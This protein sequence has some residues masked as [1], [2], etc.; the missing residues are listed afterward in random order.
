VACASALWA[1]AGSWASKGPVPGSGQL[2]P[3]PCTDRR[4]FDGTTF[5]YRACG[6]PDLD[7]V[8]VTANG[9][10]GL[11][12]NG[13]NFCATTSTM[14]WLAYLAGKGFVDAPAVKDWTDQANFSEMSNEIAALGTLMGTTASGGTGGG[15]M[16]EGTEQWL[17]AH[18]TPQTTLHA[19]SGSLNFVTKSFTAGG[20]YSPETTTMLQDAVDGG[21]VMPVIGFYAN[22][23][24]PGTDV[25]HLRRVG[26]HVVSLVSGAGA[27]A[28]TAATLG[29][30]DP[31]TEWIDDDIQS[32]Y[33]T[34]VWTL[35]SASQETYFSIDEQG[36]FHEY[37]G[38][39]PS[40]NGSATTLFDGYV[41]IEPKV[42]ETVVKD[43]ILILAPI[44]VVGPPSP[45][46][47]ERFTVSARV[48]DVALAPDGT[49]VPF[50]ARGR[51]GVWQLDT[52]TGR[53]TKFAGAPRGASRLTFGGPAQTLYVAGRTRLVGIDRKGRRVGQVKLDGPL[54]DLQFDSAGNRL[55]GLSLA[56]RRLRLFD[57]RL[58]P[59]GAVR[60]P[61]AAL[62][63][64]GAPTLAITPGGKF[65][66]HRNGS[67]TLFATGAPTAQ[68][69]A[70]RL[71][72]RPH[73]IR[74]KGR[75]RGLTVDDAGH[76][77]VS[78]RGKLVE[79]TPDGRRARGSAFT[80]LPAGPELDVSRSFSN[81][82]PH[83]G[84]RSLDFLPPENQRPATPDLVFSSTAHGSFTVAN[85]GQDAAGPFKVEISALAGAP[86]VYSF[87]GLAVGGSV[88][89]AFDCSRQRVL[90]IDPENQVD[91][92]D[93][94][95]N[96]GV[97][98]AC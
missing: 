86:L 77:F 68:G 52:L 44:Q 49:L 3:G 78:V 15:G 90:T 54:Q 59:R 48:E 4:S 51:A 2:N 41:T 12:G 93:E 97:A 81:F 20:Y 30:S 70:A 88:S 34:D 50:L 75:A 14:D 21:L 11:P 35:S 91:E 1:P 58:R 66:F 92:S 85:V 46:P 33:T 71:R 74:V 38:A 80:G 39:Y 32:P 60:L 73:P 36:K 26:G 31:A 7:Q 53:V 89:H 8:R 65:L 61:A 47:V 55:V 72:L 13:H 23:T 42:V 6:V 9:F 98:E 57:L 25:T 16:L 29:V 27:A 22:A 83:I 56:S 64:E 69:A 87:E 37:P 95:N 17:T 96:T 5:S 45:G 28:T 67:K 79:L 62:A 63:G 94:S 19:G 76:L 18:G 24:D 40:V 10:V 43:K 82:D 84:P